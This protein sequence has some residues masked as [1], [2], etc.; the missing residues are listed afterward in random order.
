MRL[1]FGLAIVLL[2]ASVAQAGN[3]EDA[4]LK[5]AREGK[6]LV[7]VVSADW[8]LAC[9]DMKATVIEPM[10]KDDLK[11]AIV[12]ILDVDKEPD[13]AKHVMKGDTLPQVAVYKFKKA[14]ACVRTVG[15]QSRAGI[16]NLIRK[17]KE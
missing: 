8:C 15:K 13:A 16:L 3:Y 2:F 7:V 10:K 17:I 11:D 5:A 12:Y 14:W 9:A 6:C 1:I 4:C